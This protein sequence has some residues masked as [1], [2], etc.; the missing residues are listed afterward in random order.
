[1]INII[2]QSNDYKVTKRFTPVSHYNEPDNKP[3]KIAIFIDTETTGS[4]SRKD[5]IIELALIPF[6]YDNDGK[7]YKI[8]D[9]YIQFQ[10]PEIPIPEFITKLT[11]ID[12]EMV[13]GKSFDINKI[14]DLVSQ[15][16][17]I[18]AHHAAFDKRFIEKII[19]IFK[20]KKWAC[21]VAHID[22]RK[23]NISS[24]KLEYLAYHFGVFYKAHR[25]EIDSLIGIHILAQTLP[26]SGITALKSLLNNYQ[27]RYFKIWAE[28]C[29]FSMK[30]ILKARG[31]RWNDGTN[32]QP[33]SWYRII[34]E[35]LKES[36]LEFLY[37]EIYKK[38]VNL[39]IDEMNIF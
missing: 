34:K 7:I 31:Y 2:E 36:E 24:S 20:D 9:S 11:G 29:P 30:D 33:K 18:I 5:K 25:A 13:K 15:A 14:N 39:K 28:N 17:I 26:I 32:K 16:S 35:E 22:W 12:N 27:S 3:K 1:M 23:E 19:P 8:L 4:R 6:E 37:S 21:T 10:D 38:N